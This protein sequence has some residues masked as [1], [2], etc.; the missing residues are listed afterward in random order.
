[1]V[2]VSHLERELWKR[3]AL[4]ADTDMSKAVL[5]AMR[6]WMA[7]VGFWHGN[8]TLPELLPGLPQAVDHQAQNGSVG[9]EAG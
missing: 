4:A 3:A 9:T 2:C 7:E 5:A 1:M 6:A 8:S